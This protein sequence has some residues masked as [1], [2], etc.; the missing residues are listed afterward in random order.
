[1]SQKAN[2]NKRYEIQDIFVLE[3]PFILTKII[4]KLIFI[5]SSILDYI[6]NNIWTSLYTIIGYI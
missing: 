2:F 3:V 5:A 1:M 4:I 6:T